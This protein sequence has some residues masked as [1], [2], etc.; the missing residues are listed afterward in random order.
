MKTHRRRTPPW[1]CPVFLCH[2]RKRKDWNPLRKR[3]LSLNIF[4]QTT[5]GISGFPGESFPTFRKEFTPNLHILL[6][7]AEEDRP[8]AAPSASDHPRSYRTQESRSLVDASAAT[9]HRTAT[10]A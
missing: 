3:N 7:G 4:P 2:Q 8:E 9:P 10:H 6:H 5:R 1:T